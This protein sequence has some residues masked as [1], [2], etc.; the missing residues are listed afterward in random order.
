MYRGR[1]KRVEDNPR[2]GSEKPVSSAPVDSLEISGDVLIG[3]GLQPLRDALF[4]MREIMDSNN[5]DSIDDDDDDD[6]EGDIAST[7]TFPLDPADGDGDG[8]YWSNA[9]Q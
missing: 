9:F 6:D 4:T 1:I 3:S 5:D 2:N 8:I 7:I